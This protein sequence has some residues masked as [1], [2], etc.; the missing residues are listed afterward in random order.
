MEYLGRG[1]FSRVYHTQSNEVYKVLPYNPS[2]LR[3][4]KVLEYLSELPEIQDYATKYYSSFR[5]GNSITLVL[6]YLTGPDLFK[7]IHQDDLDYLGLIRYLIRGLNYLHEHGVV[8]RDIKLNNILLDKGIPKYID[9]GFACIEDDLSCLTQSTG[10]PFYLSPELVR[11]LSGT[12]SGDPLLWDKL[13]SSDVWALGITFYVLIHHGQYPY[14]E[15]SSS[16]PIQFLIEQIISHIPIRSETLYPEVD[17]IIN[18]MLI[19]DYT[20]R[21]TARQLMEL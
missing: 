21:P 3:E 6:S 10:T 16:N 12:R 5:E 1:C 17:N 8:H 11:F 7:M 18:L 4:I 2:T 19:K 20:K 13:M 14:T 9:F 15:S